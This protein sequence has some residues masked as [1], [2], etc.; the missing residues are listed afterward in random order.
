MTI[1]LTVLF[2][3]ILGSEFTRC[4]TVQ[5]NSGITVEKKAVNKMAFIMLTFALCIFAGMRSG[6][7]DTGYYM[8][9]F[10]E[11]KKI[12][13]SAALDL[14]EPGFKIWTILL[15]K[16]TDNPQIFLLICSFVTIG[17][18]FSTVY[19][20]SQNVQLSLYLFITAGMLVSTMNGLRQYLVIATLFFAYKLILE[21]K[22]LYYIL[23]CLLLASIH[24]SVLLMIPVFFYVQSKPWS[25]RKILLLVLVLI[26][27]AFRGDF[28][29]QMLSEGLSEGQYSNY[30]EGL[31]SDNSRTANVFRVMVMCVPAVL[32]FIER[33]KFDYEDKE[34]N[35]C[36]NMAVLTAL[37][38][39]MTLRTWVFA[40][41]AMYFGVYSLLLYPML[42]NKI[43]ERNKKIVLI[44]FYFFYFVFF[45]IDTRSVVYTNYYL[46]INVD[47]IGFFT[48]GFYP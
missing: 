20:Y 21:K 12:P 43:G 13:L 38:Y 29:L 28:L 7:G 24:T 40:R 32:S 4:Y 3:T 11:Y 18:I 10:Q 1:W 9:N 17:M 16:I 30:S 34:Y 45:Y 25:R 27:I 5:D 42:L 36:S 41:V 19:K 37:C 31:V 33:N 8:Y 6:I 23:L 14:K 2:I 39:C 15:G 44:L 48:R 47:R 46:G 35:V 22:T 26:L